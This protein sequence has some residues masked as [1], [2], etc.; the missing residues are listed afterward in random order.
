MTTSLRA[1]LL[2][3]VMDG[4]VAILNLVNALKAEATAL[5]FVTVDFSEV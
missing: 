3:D 4:L 2:Q 5:D 1:F